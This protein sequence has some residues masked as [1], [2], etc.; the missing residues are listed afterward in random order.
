MYRE[1]S[2]IQF[3]TEDFGHSFDNNMDEIYKKFIQ[4]DWYRHTYIGKTA[5]H[6]NKF[7]QYK[8]LWVQK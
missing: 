8:S 1:E 7:Y 5:H 2:L 3:E 4:H 6:Q